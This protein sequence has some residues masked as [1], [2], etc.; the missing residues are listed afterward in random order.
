MWPHVACAGPPDPKTLKFLLDTGFNV[1]VTNNKGDTPLHVAASLDPSAFPS[2]DPSI[3][4]E[5]L[6]ILLDGSAHHDF[7]NNKGETA[8]DVAKT[9]EARRILSER[10]KMEL[11][12][13][14][15]RAVKK[16]G[17]SYQ[18]MVPKTLEKFISMH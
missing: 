2:F 6:E 16:F 7:V 8:F 9:D 10:K 18:G 1:N 11:K 5:T 12:C 13:I 3:L 15:A 17:L 4:M 14:S